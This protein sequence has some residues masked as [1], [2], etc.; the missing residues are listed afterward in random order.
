MR[1]NG[2]M[3]LIAVM[4][5]A[6]VMS[7]EILG[8]MSKLRSSRIADAGG[9]D[10]REIRAGMAGDLFQFS[11]SDQSL[12][13]ELVFLGPTVAGSRGLRFLPDPAMSPTALLFGQD[14]DQDA[15]RD[16]GLAAYPASA[17][18]G[19]SGPV[20]LSEAD[21]TPSTEPAT[22]SSEFS[23]PDQVTSFAETGGGGGG[24]GPPEPSTVLEPPSWLMLIL[25][26]GGLGLALR[27]G[28]RRTDRL[29]DDCAPDNLEA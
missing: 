8:P 17:S 1:L 12:L 4:C 10:G 16:A 2:I 3:A 23:F 5:V 11:P 24:T 25:G 27:H 13:D 22:F 21:F 9:N 6:G 20:A 14:G 15:W 29:P 26:L 28:R 19:L 7:G 18:G